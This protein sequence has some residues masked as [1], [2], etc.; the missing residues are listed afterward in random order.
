MVENILFTLRRI[1]SEWYSIGQCL[2]VP[3]EKRNEIRSQHSTDSERLKAVLLYVLTLHPRASWRCVINAL[4]KMRQDQ[5]AERIQDFCEPVTGMLIKKRN[6]A[7]ALV[8]AIFA[9]CLVITTTVRIDMD[10]SLLENLGIWPPP[11][12]I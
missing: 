10:N 5:V 11:S 7:T 4:C 9:S 6:I 1:E 12:I 2:Y 8:H 3:K